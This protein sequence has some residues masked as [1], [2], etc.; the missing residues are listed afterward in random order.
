MI[1]YNTYAP[2]DEEMMEIMVNE[3][4]LDEN[5]AD[6]DDPI[7]LDGKPYVDDETG[8]WTQDAHDSEHSYTLVADKDGNIKIVP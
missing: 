3:F 6:S 5:N 2:M 8:E 7:I 1:E 4:L